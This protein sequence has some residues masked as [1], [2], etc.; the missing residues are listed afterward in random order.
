MKIGE[1]MWECKRVWSETPNEVTV[2]GFSLSDD[3]ETLIIRNDF[4]EIAE[5]RTEIPLDPFA[6]YL[7]SV[8]AMVA[9]YELASK[10]EN[11]KKSSA[12]VIYQTA[13]SDYALEHFGTNGGNNTEYDTIKWRIKTNDTKYYA[14]WLSMLLTYGKNDR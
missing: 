13:K 14:V 6:E 12:T 10:C 1:L 11:D 3:G 5:A 7:F 2:N 9:D 4:Y 8:E